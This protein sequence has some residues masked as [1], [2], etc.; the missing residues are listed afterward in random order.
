MQKNKYALQLLLVL[1]LILLINLI[2]FHV[3]T[4]NIVL[5]LVQLICLVYTFLYL[6]KKDNVNHSTTLSHGH[7]IDNELF[8]DSLHSITE[9][10]DQ[11]TTIINSD[12]DRAKTFV[13][14]AVNG[15]SSSFL[16]LQELNAKQQEMISALIDQN[17]SIGDNEGTNL[18]NFVNNSVKTLDDFVGVIVNTSKQSLLTMSYTDEMVKQFDGVFTLLEQVQNLANQTNLLALNA[19]IEA[20]RAGDAGRGFAVVANEVRSLSVNST[21]LNEDIRKE[22]HQAQIIID[23]LRKSVEV[24]ASAD[25]TSTL[26]AK[27]KVSEMM[28]HVEQ[29][30][31][32]TAEGIDK[33]SA[34]T[35]EIEETVATGVRLLQFED[36]TTQTLYSLQTELL[37]IMTINEKLKNFEQLSSGQDN[38]YLLR[39]KEKSQELKN[40][41][42]SHKDRTVM[43]SSMNEG[44]VELF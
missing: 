17:R 6:N 11:T 29:V 2:S 32:E 36:L 13:N 26:E 24:M 3:Y 22:I 19:A 20:A 30:N 1:S 4:L 27:N 33:L 35:P 14:E 5:V 21:E 25:M 39:I 34:L 12:A 38:E 43:Q 10:L 28:K 41:M 37:N 23:K 18:E 7:K 40:L 31:L 16:E 44:E 9:L 15:V 42:N 8:R